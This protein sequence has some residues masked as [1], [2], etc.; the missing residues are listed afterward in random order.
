MFCKCISFIVGSVYLHMLDDGVECNNLSLPCVSH[1]IQVR[2][3]TFCSSFWAWRWKC[4]CCL[5]TCAVTVLS[6][7]SNYYV[8]HDLTV[9]S[10][11]LSWDLLCCDSCLTHLRKLNVCATEMNPRDTRR[12]RVNWTT[13]GSELNNLGLLRL[14]VMS[15]IV[16]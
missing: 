13:N 9:T 8:T 2:V 4:L 6:L 7:Q 16:C 3:S 12:T 1:N 5:L 14:Q 11:V 15:K 10:P